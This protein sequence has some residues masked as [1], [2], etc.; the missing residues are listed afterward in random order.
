[1]SNLERAFVTVPVQ[2]NRAGIYTI[3]G[4]DIRDARRVIPTGSPAT[5]MVKT[6]AGFATNQM[7]ICPSVTS[8]VP[9]NYDADH[10]AIDASTVYFSYSGDVGQFSVLPPDSM[11]IPAETNTVTFPVQALPTAP[12]DTK[13]KIIVTR[14]NLSYIDV[15]ITRDT[16]LLSTLPAPS[17]C[18][19]RTPDTVCAGQPVTI[20]AV[21]CDNN[22]PLS[23][24]S[25]Q[26]VKTQGG[27]PSDVQ[28]ET[29]QTYTFIPAVGD[30]ISC[31]VNPTVCPSAPA[32]PSNDLPVNVAPRLIPSIQ[33]KQY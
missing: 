27:I 5:L 30:V 16:I 8:N 23:G 2:G 12:Y 9:V 33:I 24:I 7:V 28:G 19:F 32:I 31:K 1:M 17:V 4:N 13:L 6:R 14:V 15:N 21:S 3:D 22:L 29:A 20:S 25:Y 26:W 11:I 18:I 10:M